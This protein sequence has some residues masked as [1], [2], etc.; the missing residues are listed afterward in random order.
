VLRVSDIVLLLVALAAAPKRDVN[1]SAALYVDT[2]WKATPPSAIPMPTIRPIS[3]PV[4]VASA[5][6]QV[7]KECPKLK[8]LSQWM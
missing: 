8:A 6:M 4:D 5:Y 2:P 3:A 1:T 7:K